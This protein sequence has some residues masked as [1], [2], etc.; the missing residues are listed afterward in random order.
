MNDSTALFPGVSGKENNQKSQQR[1]QILVFWQAFWVIGLSVSACRRLRVARWR[2]WSWLKA[3]AVRRLLNSLWQAGVRRAPWRLL[4]QRGGD[5]RCHR[6]LDC[7]WQ[8]QLYRRTGK[9]HR[10]QWMLSTAAALQFW[11]ADAVV[12]VSCSLKADLIVVS[13]WIWERE[14]GRNKN[15]LPRKSFSTLEDSLSFWMADLQTAALT[16]TCNSKHETGSEH[17][18]FAR[19]TQSL[20]AEN[21]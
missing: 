5:W 15:Q 8:E 18:D 3:G 6:C 21:R 13:W 11:L 7:V 9:T 2:P 16:A 10:N 4:L 1:H 14:T 19:T 17:N 12:L 20:S